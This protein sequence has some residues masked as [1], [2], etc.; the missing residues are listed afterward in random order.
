[1]LRLQGMDYT[2][3]KLRSM[4]R[5]WQTLIEANVDVKTTDGFTLRMFCIAFTKKRQG[6]IKRTAYAQSSQVR[7]ADALQHTPTTTC[8][9]RPGGEQ[10][11]AAHLACSTHLIYLDLEIAPC[12]PA[13]PH[14]PPQDGGDHGARGRILRP[15]GPG[16]K[17]HP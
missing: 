14:H 5:K 6:Q 17:V 12:T 2:T 10:L 9:L 1:M 3:D 8:L 7:A 16:G 4:V 11:T 13:D 15:Q